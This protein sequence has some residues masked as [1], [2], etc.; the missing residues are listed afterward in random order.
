MLDVV[1]LGELAPVVGR[2]VLLELVEGLPAEVAAVDEEEHPP[3]PGELDQAVDEVTAVKV[4]PVPVAIWMRARGR[5][6]AKE[7]SRLRWPRS[8][9]PQALGRQGRH[10]AQAGAQGVGLTGPLDSVSGRWKAKT[11][12]LRGSGSRVS[13]K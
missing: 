5:S 11:R 8:G 9:A 3:G 13:V 10:L 12:R 4:L 1:E 6:S 2:D 7:R